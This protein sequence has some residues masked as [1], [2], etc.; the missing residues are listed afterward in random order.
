MRKRTL[1][2]ICL[3][4]VLVLATLSVSRAADP[5]APPPDPA[6]PADAFMK[7][8]EQFQHD[9]VA[10]AAA[11]EALQK[12]VDELR[13]QAL[14]T[15]EV[16]KAREAIAD[17]AAK[18]QELNARVGDLTKQL[19][20]AR[21]DAAELE[22]KI[23][24][25]QQQID[26]AQQSQAEAATPL[27]VL[28]RS[29][30]LLK[31]LEPA[32]PAE[33]P[34]APAPETPV[35][36]EPAVAP[37]PDTAAFLSAHAVLSAN[38]FACHGPEKQKSGLR[39][40]SLESILKGGT[41]GPALVPG[42]PDKS[43]LIQAIRYDGELQMPPKGKLEQAEID[44]LVQW[45]KAGAIWSDAP[46]SPSTAPAV[47]APVAPPAP[48]PTPVQPAANVSGEIR[49]NRDIRPILSNNCFA[50]HGMDHATRK[51][52]LRLDDGKNAFETLPS[53]N[54]ALMPG[55]RAKSELF[56]RITSANPDEKMPPAEAKKELTPEQ[57][58]LLGRWIDEGAHYE[59]HW[60][61]VPPERPEPPAVTAEDWTRNDI[62]RFILAR[63]EQEGL[64]PAPE[65]DRA[66]LIRRVT[67]DLTG[68]PPTPAEVDA[69]VND[70]S[71][72]AYEKLVDRLLATPQYGE[73]MTRY[74]LDLARYADTNGY[75]IDNE[76]Y[77]WRWRDWVIDAFNSNLPYD[78]FTIQQLAGDLLPNPTLEQR[79]ASGFNRNHMVT[80]EGGIIPEEYRVEY[81][82]NRVNTTSTVW[83][84]L[85]VSCAQCHD[86]KFDPISHRD[87]YGLY[88]FFNNIAEQ[89]SDGRDGNAAPMMPAPTPEQDRKRAALDA[90]IQAILDKMHRP[91][92][93]L[94]AAQAEW[95][96]AQAQTLQARWTV[97]QPSELKST[98]GATLE[99]REDGSV[100][101]T[102]DN[103]DKDVYEFVA[104]TDVT[105]I[106]AI[107]LEALADPSLPKG[108]AGRFDNANFVLSEFE[109]EVAPAA[110]PA[111]ATPV[112]FAA[113]NADFSQ[114]KFDI[115][116]AIDG[117][118]ETGWA[119]A[120]FDRPESRT[121]I[122]MPR[123]RIG[124]PGGSL[125][126]I[127]LK[128]ESEFAKHAIGRFRL[129]VTADPAMAP[130]D[131]GPWY[132]NGPYKAETGAKALETAWEPETAVDLEATYEDGR[133]KWL[134][135]PEFKDGEPNNLKGDVGATYLYRVIKVS[136][137]R[138]VTFGFGCNDTMKVWLNGK[139][140]HEH[141]QARG[142]IA[143]S[144]R[145]TATLEPGE[146]RLLMKVANEGGKH[147]F[148][149]RVAE[150]QIGDVP[151]DVEAALLLAKDSRSEDQ[152]RRVRAFYRKSHWPEWEPLETQLASV[153]NE[154]SDLEA[155][156]PTAM[157]MAELEKPRETFILKR[158]QYD[159]PTEK[160]TPAVPAVLP[161]LPADAPPNRLGL[162]Q[163]LV[164]PDHPLTARVAVN[165][166]WAR[167]FGTGIVK[168]VEDFGIQ[169][170][171]PSHP[172]LLDWLATE[173]IRTGWDVKALQRLIVTSAAY[174]QSSRSTPELRKRD[175]ENRLLA[176]G[177]RFRMD[178]EMIR[179]AALAVS[180]LLVPTIGGP[181]VKPYQPE[182]IWEEVSYGDPNFTAQSYTQ[183]HGEALYR[184]SMYIFWKR[185]APPPSMVVFDAP[186]REVCTARRARTN[187]PLQA[188]VLMNDPQYVEAARH[189]AA[190]M[191]KD[192]GAAPEERIAYAFRLATARFPK[193]EETAVLAEIFKTQL[194]RYRQNTEAAKQLLAVGESPR[195]ETLDPAE[196]AAW[197]TVASMILNLD[198]T[199]TKS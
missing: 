195:D 150:Q 21:A 13:K 183:D 29:L 74:W 99:K 47:E 104:T 98:G 89:G 53:G 152:Q 6:P 61:F 2:P 54:I 78:Q 144:D 37:A 157:V 188:L 140:I 167:Y 123:E 186:N 193:P 161:P 113:A 84:G 70:T 102:G 42:D 171:L 39:L 19:E 18:A 8:L 16:E 165:R 182:G 162:A 134:P 125:L 72:D 155:S 94:D 91:V 120:G 137:P 33:T 158:G 151:V 17:N 35:P 142:T 147:G 55:D 44:A 121:A 79:L 178:A 75:H 149:F 119:A 28:E 96:G 148:F 87:Y 115:A 23:Q 139:L 170:D 110:D 179:D 172:E 51:A 108:G 160:V 128:H 92:P 145:V 85:T 76:R 118:P 143:D 73:H 52:G 159:Q 132:M 164:S 197:T 184:R 25:T 100:L 82:V 163:W 1:L 38:C 49:F 26:A 192:G 169:G 34:A 174:R 129:A 45:I 4:S 68:L 63:L 185:T 7:L 77:M 166:F 22:K 106:T 156:I 56:Q 153:R 30:E 177:P 86:H 20:A 199:V 180:G 65:A 146:N 198:E 9:P 62:D 41:Q 11:R 136:A 154:R 27:F 138:T 105:G 181:S 69:F 66:T 50:C 93:D 196:H 10:R 5:P 97:L 133:V 135:A 191:I 24:S 194:E 127:R 117:K 60:A 190:R 95:E 31:A 80:F 58:E 131:L 141:A 48:V 130:A 81:V 173:F 59:P 168:T 67:L 124:F 15:A 88:A 122:F 64:K 3:L 107:R 57:I 114:E 12:R 175:P 71:P 111:E 126:R 112:A 36:A 43:L 187:T 103:P 176:R 14:D 101:A 40:D 83:M 46:A 32:P 189:L 116:G 109:V 90:E